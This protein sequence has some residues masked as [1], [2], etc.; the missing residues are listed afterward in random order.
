MTLFSDLD[1]AILAECS[2]H[3]LKVARIIGDVRVRLEPAEINPELIDRIIA[4]VEAGRL[5]GDG[6]LTRW[7]YSEVRLPA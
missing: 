2:P 4:L 7:R 3:F 6:N 1:S 5:E